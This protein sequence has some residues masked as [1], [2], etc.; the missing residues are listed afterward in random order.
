VKLEKELVQR[1]RAE[2]RTTA[3]KKQYDITERHERIS[4]RGYGNSRRN[5][6]ALSRKVVQILWA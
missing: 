1:G 4:V 3:T 6:G 5:V 2:K